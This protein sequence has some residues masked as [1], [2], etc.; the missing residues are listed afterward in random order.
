MKQY[1]QIGSAAPSPSQRQARKWFNNLS[2]STLRASVGLAVAAALALAGCGGG[3][4]VEAP[5]PG[6]LALAAPDA[7]TD[8]GRAATSTVAATA[9]AIDAAT[10]TGLTAAPSVADDTRRRVQLADLGAVAAATPTTDDAVRL[11]QQATFGPSEALNAEIKA[12]GIAGWIN[13]QLAASGSRYTSGGDGRLHQP[14]SVPSYCK[15]TAQRSN[16]DCWRDYYSSE[17]LLWDFYRNATTR[18]DQLRQRMALALHQILV[19]SAVEVQGTYGLR[20][21]Q[22]NF[23]DLAFANYRDVLRKVLLSPVMGDYLDSVNNDP[24]APN[25]NLAREMLQLFS[26]G[27]CLLNGDGSLQG[28]HCVPTYDNQRVRNYAYALTGWTY[29]RGGSAT[30]KCS[31]LADVNCLYYGGDMVAAP[32][33]RDPAQ[34]SLLSGVSVPAGTDAA[35]ALERVLDSVMQHPNVAPFIARRLIQSFVR[36]APSAAYVQRVA[37]AFAS[38]SYSQLEGSRTY[39]FG[40]GKKGDLAATV[41]AVL[42]DGEARAT[43]PVVANAGHLRSPALLF[44]GAVR[45]LN[46]RTDGNALGAWWGEALQQHVFRAPSVFSYYPPD[47]PVAGTTLAGP[48]FGIHNASAALNRLNYLRYLIDG[49]DVAPDPSVPGA[50]GTQLRLADFN[51]SAADAGALVD[52]I[53]GVVLGHPLAGNPRAQV[54]AAVEWWSST[55]APTDWRTRRI[56]TAAYLVMA[57]PDYQVQR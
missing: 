40:A 5:P 15:Q 21:Y 45:A 1:A 35:T 43:T 2:F 9:T 19:T 34:R 23:L 8:A 48:E 3:G 57:S 29:P 18:N 49:G 6:A 24:A 7:H 39:R 11:A 52:R 42:L 46:G 17:P 36:S 12:A 20:I 51:S 27:T 33:L 44:A 55:R 14:A 31:A 54:V 50:I 25:E 56:G 4:S 53:A 26:L 47:Y 28:G 22:N 13:A 38:G 32:S 37:N 30:W 10:A 41:A 16:P